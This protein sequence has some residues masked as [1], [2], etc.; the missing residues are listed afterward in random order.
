MESIKEKKSKKK[1]SAL[2]YLYRDLIICFHS[3][4]FGSDFRTSLFSRY[5]CCCFQ[6]ESR[7]KKPPPP[8]SLL[9]IWFV[10]I[11]FFQFP[12]IV[13][14]I[15]TVMW[16][17]FCEFKFFFRTITINILDHNKCWLTNLSRERYL[18]KIQESICIKNWFMNYEFL[19]QKK[20][21]WNIENGK[22]LRNNSKKK[23]PK[24]SEIF[25]PHLL[26]IKQ[27]NHEWPLEL[28]KFF[29]FVR[30]I[31]IVIGYHI[32][33]ALSW[34]LTWVFSHLLCAHHQACW[35]K[36]K[37]KINTKFNSIFLHFFFDHLL[38][39]DHIYSWYTSWHTYI[40]W[41]A[42]CFYISATP[43]VHRS[44][45]F[46]EQTILFGPS[47]LWKLKTKKKLMRPFA[48]NNY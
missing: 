42:F 6:I 3:E 17:F 19:D 5:S 22:Y 11:H 43:K 25:R 28:F 38:F 32:R 39:L 1:K 41:P 16:S 27:T 14:L 48:I 30:F 4:K 21:W 37:R 9:L 20:W 44:W 40:Q 35:L 29:F 18:F 7:R 13:F 33:L 31:S 34:H 36:S 8:P 2:I 15:P 24:Q 46:D 26:R 10:I 23:F 47:S 45:T 12:L